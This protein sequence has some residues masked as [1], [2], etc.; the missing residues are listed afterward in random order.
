MKI[1]KSDRGTKTIPAPSPHQRSRHRGQQRTALHY[2][3]L[4]RTTTIRCS[5]SPSSQS[6]LIG[7]LAPSL[8]PRSGH[9]EE[10]KDRSKNAT[11]RYLIGKTRRQLKTKKTGTILS[12]VAWTEAAVSK[13]TR[14][15]CLGLA[16]GLFETPWGHESNC[17]PPIGKTDQGSYCSKGMVSVNSCASMSAHVAIKREEAGRREA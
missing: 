14:R 8:E 10:K 17:H 9:A 2:G 13:P 16:L 11:P 3:S 7:L 15:T 1:Q 12:I 4:H 5:K 6:K